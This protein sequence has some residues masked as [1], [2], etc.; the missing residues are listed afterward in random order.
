MIV[1]VQK[2][3]NNESNRGADM[4][5]NIDRI[6]IAERIRKEITNIEALA[7]DIDSNGLINPI[8][9]MESKG[10]GEY[11]LLAGFRQ[12]KRLAGQR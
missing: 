11:R 12:H 6:K 5:I 4:K 3:Y 7:A 8:T 1:R 10:D 2:R 9:V